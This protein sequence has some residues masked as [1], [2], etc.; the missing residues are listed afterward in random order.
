MRIISCQGENGYFGL[1]ALSSL[2][3]IGQMIEHTSPTEER[4]VSDKGKLSPQNPV[5][6]ELD[7]KPAFSWVC[8]SCGKSRW[9]QPHTELPWYTKD[10]FVL[11]SLSFYFFFGGV[12]TQNLGFARQVLYHFK[13]IQPFFALV[14]F[15][16]GSCIFCVGLA[17]DLDPPNYV[18]YLT[19]LTDICRHSCFVG[20]NGVSLVF[21]QDWPQGMILLISAS[22][23]AGTIVVSFLFWDRISL[24][25]SDSP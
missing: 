10:K 14:V 15:Q 4:A 5:F 7:E 16:I 3:A 6:W 24:G 17:L 9:T 18:F 1:W 20:W 11:T 13:L 22:W 19:G 23:V 12:W 25:S 8:G 21:C 2:K